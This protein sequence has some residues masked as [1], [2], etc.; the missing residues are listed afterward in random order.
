M[1]LGCL[2]EL[3][4][5]QWP[6]VSQTIDTL[7]FLQIYLVL[8][9]WDICG[10]KIGLCCIQLLLQQLCNRS[11]PISPTTDVSKLLG[12]LGNH[13]ILNTKCSLSFLNLKNWYC[14]YYVQH[15]DNQNDVL[16]QM[17]PAPE[18]SRFGLPG[19][20]H[21]KPAILSPGCFLLLP[22]VHHLFPTC[23][24]FFFNTPLSLSFA[25]RIFNA[26]VK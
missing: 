17:S 6:L 26:F 1:V 18:S 16:S 23:L 20:D 24:N 10:E 9:Q 13:I 11:N 8:T 14:C 15:H 5:L 25:W 3:C 2:F 12:A 21:P 19:T 22:L 4:R 7:L